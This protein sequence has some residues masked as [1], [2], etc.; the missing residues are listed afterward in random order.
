MLAVLAVTLAAAAPARASFVFDLNGS[1]LG[2]G[3]TGPFAQVSV[4][5]TSSSTATI[6][7]TSLTN[8][9]FLYLLGGHDAAALNVNG[10]FSFGSAVGSNALAGFT[11]GPYSAG[12]PG[13]DD[14]AGS[15]NLLIDSFDG[16]THSADTITIMLTG[17]SGWTDSTVLAGNT[18]GNIAA[19]H[20]FACAEPGCSVTSGA[21]KTG[22]AAGNGG[23][24]PPQ[25][26]PEPST[27]ALMALG[28]LAL[29]LI[30]R[31]G[32]V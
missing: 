14:G 6:V 16:F 5:A 32:E 1:N 8:G 4:T 25:F 2:S 26:I 18:L 27:V 3:F 24:G 15:F 21:V 20:V 19:A 23:G 7:F 11:P 17:G 29:G 30:R 22:D 13:N 10:A 28:L 31:K 9:G 12:G